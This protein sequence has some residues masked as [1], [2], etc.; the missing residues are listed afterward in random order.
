MDPLREYGLL[1]LILIV[2]GATIYFVHDERQIGAAKVIAAQAAADAKEAVHVQQVEANAADTVSSLQA[3][4]T[5]Q[6]AAPPHPTVVVRMCDRTTSAPSAGGAALPGPAGDAAGGPSSGVGEDD[7]AAPTELILN[8]D[9]AMIDYLQ[10]Y[11]RAC[12]TAGA[13]AK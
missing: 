4:L 9:K 11:V 3:R 13:C 2:L 7:I 1:A 12:Q 8:R 5:S 10:G 6:V